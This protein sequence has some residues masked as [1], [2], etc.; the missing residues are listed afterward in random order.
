MSYQTQTLILETYLSE[1]LKKS[2]QS[3]RASTIGEGL[4][5]LSW[6]KNT[7]KTT[8]EEPVLGK[9]N[10]SNTTFGPLGTNI[11]RNTK[12][13]ALKD[14]RLV[15]VA[16]IPSDNGNREGEHSNGYHCANEEPKLSKKGTP[17]EKNSTNG[18]LTL[19]TKMCL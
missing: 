4:T 7:D 12:S 19:L 9:F 11:Y 14:N 17:S 16:E 15:H 13:V 1:D 3:D 8:K 5:N 2:A 18:P 6:V 10:A